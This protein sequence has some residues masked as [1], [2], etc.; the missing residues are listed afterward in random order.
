M[1]FINS[2]RNPDHLFLIKVLFEFIVDNMHNSAFSV[3]GMSS[4]ANAHHSPNLNTWGSPS[5]GGPLAS[6][7][8]DS[9]V[10]SRTHYQSGYLMV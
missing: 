3:A 6:S 10:Q 9:L 2:A 8:S 5:T 7:F 4:S 1:R